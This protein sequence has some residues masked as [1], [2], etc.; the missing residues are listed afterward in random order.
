VDTSIR[1]KINKP[2]VI[3]ETFEDE[4]VVINLDTGSY[5]SL[6]QTG[7]DIW[8]L[9]DSGVTVAEMTECMC[10]LHQGNRR[11]IETAVHAFIAELEKE[12]LIVPHLNIETA[13]VQCG[14]GQMNKQT[15]HEKTPFKAPS[16]QKFTDMQ[17][18]L[19]LDPIHEVDEKG[20]PS[21]KKDSKTGT[22]K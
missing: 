19:L 6:T 2:E 11:E 13:P 4:L 15:T 9:I 18:L 8:N 12:Q 21:A 1:F 16:L 22:K 17:D 20:W 3:F 7:S 14:C 5:Y 10:K